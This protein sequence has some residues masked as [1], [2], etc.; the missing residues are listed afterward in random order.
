MKCG[1]VPELRTM[2][3]G[4]QLHQVPA[5]PI[6]HS[7]I[8][9]QDLTDRR[10]VPL[11][12]HPA[13][14]RKLLQPLDSP[15]YVHQR[16]VRHSVPN[17]WRC[18]PRSPPD[19]RQPDRSTLLQ[20]FGHLLL[21]LSVRDRLTR[22]SLLQTTRDLGQKKQPLHRVLERRIRGQ[23]VNGFQHLFFRGH[24]AMNTTAVP[25]PQSRLLPD[26]MAA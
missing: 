17:P 18:I 14:L 26:I 1:G 8:A 4:H 21:H 15:A 5:Y 24:G 13:R 10:I 2:M 9:E 11:R 6:N 7:I 23:V 20:P 16:T 25:V 3:D 19:S 12:H 22:V